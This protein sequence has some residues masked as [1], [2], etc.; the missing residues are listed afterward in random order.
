MGRYVQ[1]VK[2]FQLDAHLAPYD[3]ASH[4][5]WRQLSC[6]VSGAVVDALQ[7]VGGNINILAEADPALLR[8]ATAAEEALYA[9]LAK[10]REAAAAAGG[11]SEPG[12]PAAGPEAE[13]PG[14][15]PTAG[16]APAAAAGQQGQ[17][18]DEGGRWSAAPHAGRCFY[19]PLPRL[20]KRGGLSPQELTGESWGGVGG[21]A[22]ACMG[23]RLL[24]ITLAVSW[25]IAHLF[26]PTT[27]LLWCWA[28]P[29]APDLRPSN[30]ACA[31]PCRLPKLPLMLLLIPTTTMHLSPHIPPPL[32]H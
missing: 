15:H 20:V 23:G 27:L 11:G 26:A 2:S 29:L 28:Q 18:E 22:R 8:P 4:N 24:R 32:Q 30:A 1:A 19:T 25:G 12:A 6:H 21:R 5:A 31:I 10:G 9:Q 13:Q 14:Q 7:P 3:L 17:A 16:A